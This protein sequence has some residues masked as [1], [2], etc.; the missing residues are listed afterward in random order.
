F[1]SYNWSNGTTMNRL[2]IRN[3]GRYTLEVK[4]AD[5]C[6]GSDTILV[7]T[8]QCLMD[9]YI[10]NAFTPNRDGKNDVFKPVTFGTPLSYRL[11]IYN[12]WGQMIFD[13]TDSSK[14]WDGYINGV[15]QGNG[16]YAYTL[17]YQIEGFEPMLKKGTVTLIN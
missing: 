3:A 5:G 15:R 1:A 2:I 16:T 14:G 6:I 17:S 10:P 12:R 8:R 9:V 11:T 7:S 13:T 4:D